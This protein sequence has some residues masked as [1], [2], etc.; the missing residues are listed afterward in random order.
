M[1]LTEDVL[2]HATKKV[3]DVFGQ[4]NKVS[5]SGLDE[6]C[7]GSVVAMK[8]TTNW[9]F[10]LAR[11]IF[12]RNIR[13]FA[14]RKAFRLGAGYFLRAGG[15]V[16]LTNPLTSKSQ[17]Q[18]YQ[19]LRE[20]YSI[21]AAGGVVVYAPEAACFQNGVGGRIFPRF[22]IKAGELKLKSFLVGTNYKGGGVIEVKAEQYDPRNKPQQVVEAEIRERLAALSGLNEL[23]REVPAL[24]ARNY[25]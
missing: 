22:I 5:T 2:W 6:I 11:H 18:D 4:I 16:P 17:T 9:D 24:P 23:E 1:G 13:I 3:T 20:F 12:P 19:T 15:F 14:T 21:L 8:H 7:G 10:F 25:R